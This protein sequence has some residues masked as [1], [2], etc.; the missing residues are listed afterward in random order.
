MDDDQTGVDPASAAEMLSVLHRSNAKTELEVATKDGV[1]PPALWVEPLPVITDANWLRADILYAC[2]HEQR[3]TLVTAANEQFVRPFAALHVVDEILEHGSEWAE[4]ATYPIDGEEFVSRFHAEYLPLLRVVPDDG[5]PW[6]WISPEEQLRLSE[7][8]A[9]DPDDVPS[10]MLALSIRG[11]FLSRDKPALRAVYGDDADSAMQAEWLTL[12]KA[13]GDAG[14]VMRVL[15]GI[16]GIG[17]ATGQGVASLARRSYAAIGPLSIALAIGVTYGAWRWLRHPSRQGLRS[18][19]MRALDLL[20]RLAV[21]QQE[22]R[23][24]FDG[25]LPPPA[26]W[27]L[28]GHGASP[29]APVGRAALH[30]LARHRSGH[31]SARELTGELAPTIKCT[32]QQV[33]ALL[34][35]APCFE[36]VYRGR[37]QV[38]QALVRLA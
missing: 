20:A 9:A 4:T 37:W 22:Q 19:L 21:L 36:E 23:R 18:G 1:F 26:T 24:L 25:A 30:A 31:L 11:L 5:I 34:R 6:T 27:E 15:G 17:I 35:S 10:A 7:L 14:Q 12:L 2:R 13:G 16:G 33:R 3:T 38:G 28:F 32:E 29:D 8:R